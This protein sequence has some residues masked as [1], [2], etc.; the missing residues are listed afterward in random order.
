[1]FD[2]KA[3]ESWKSRV[4]GRT[5]LWREGRLFDGE[6]T[7]VVASLK[8]GDRVA[9]AIASLPQFGGLFATVLQLIEN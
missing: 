6:V 7:T 5:Y 2:I 3:V 9:R 1:M 4:E 8:F